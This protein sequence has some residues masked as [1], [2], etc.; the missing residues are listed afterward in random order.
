[1]DKNKKFEF[2]MENREKDLY[3]IAFSYMKNE[4]DAMDCVQD[5]LIKGMEN[6]DSLQNK[7]Y[8]DS[9][10]IRIL[11]NTCKDS[12]NMRKKNLYLGDEIDQISYSP[13]DSEDLLDLLASLESLDDEERAY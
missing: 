10:M 7:E 6:F 4:A 13:K 8:F 12:L 9:W 2:F 1:M 3:R 11:I 5:S